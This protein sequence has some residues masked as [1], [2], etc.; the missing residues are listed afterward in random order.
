MNKIVIANGIKS[1]MTTNK[2]QKFKNDKNFEQRKEMSS[3]HDSSLTL[4]KTY[5]RKSKMAYAS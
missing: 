2:Y 5:S 3:L 4:F 1:K